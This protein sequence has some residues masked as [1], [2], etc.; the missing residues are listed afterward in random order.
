M[1]GEEGKVEI[2]LLLTSLRQIELG[3]KSIV[4]LGSGVVGRK[5]ARVRA[6]VT[7][8]RV[9]E[10]RGRHEGEEGFWVEDVT[11]IPES[12]AGRGSEEGLH[13]DADSEV[14]LGRSEILVASH[15][16]GVAEDGKKSIE[17]SSILGFSGFSFF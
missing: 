6:S 16:R 9:T 8:S 2:W 13:R 1:K 14:L 4:M 12:Q 10:D 11:V 15:S 7:S 17:D 5:E 3:A